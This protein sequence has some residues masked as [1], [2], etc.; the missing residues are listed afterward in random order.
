MKISIITVCLNSDKTIEKTIN[1]VV[2]QDYDN[3]EYIIIDGGSNDNT[4]NII[5][6][7]KNHI[8]T[9]VSEKD[10]GIYDGINKGIKKAS[11]EIISLIHANDIFVDKNVISKV[12]NFFKDNVACDIV[13]ADLAFK[14]NLD[15]KKITRYYSSRNFK[16]W[17]L[18]IGYSP[19]HL[20]T[21]IRSRVFRQVGLYQTNFKI[22]GDFD[23]FVRCF[24][25]HKLKFNYLNE[26]LIFMS[27]GGTS[28]KNILSYLTSSKEINQS[29]NS[30]NIYSNIF[31][32]FLR[33][34]VKL[35]QFILK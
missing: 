6:K 34:P 30:N 35:I 10:N 2:S 5:N 7:Y 4:L 9:I 25:K 24:L 26:C 19:P 31:L 29:L 11:G 14:K 3:I 12:A 23:Y 13:L 22:A 21:F 16:S 33:F 27:T 1:S 17:M 8:K 28:G 15:E 32:T 18:K 20:S